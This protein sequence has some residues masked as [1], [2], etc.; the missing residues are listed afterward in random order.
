MA[1]LAVACGGGGG[2][3][4]ERGAVSGTVELSDSPDDASGVLVQVGQVS[5]RTP[6]DGTFVLAGLEK[7]E[8]TLTARKEGYDPVS[9]TVQIR[10]GSRT[11][12]GTVTLEAENQSPVVDAVS[13]AESELDPKGTTT[14]TVD[15][16]DPD[17]DEL[18][19]EFSATGD[20][21]VESSSDPPNQATVTAP[22]QLEARGLVRVTVS[23]GNG[24]STQAGAP[25]RTGDNGAPRIEDLR[26]SR[27]E[28]KPGETASLAVVA[29]DPDGDELT[30]TW[31][32]PDAWSLSETDSLRTEITAPDAFG[33]EA[34]VEVSVEDEF[35]ES[36]SESITLRTG[37]N[38]APRIRA[39]EVTPPQ[40][41]PQGTAGL[42]VEA[43]DPE[44]ESLSYQWG[45]PKDWSFADATKKSTTLTAPANYGATAKIT[46][47]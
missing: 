29:S 32:A 6:A 2:K 11:D 39:V 19:Y 35:G 7:G 21:S 42:N 40:V 10:S 28:L 38:E 27:T 18:T 46:V 36:T 33:E 8:K 41:A 26:A 3:K 16:T 45:A 13:L 23:D 14:L 24:G 20:F 1:S 17:G 37:E 44:G 22:D 34:T 9:K 31:S 5:T 30:Y 47:E 15:A 25:V 4:L 12:V 43:S